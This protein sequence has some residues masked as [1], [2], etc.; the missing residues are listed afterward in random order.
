M[1]SYKYVS[2]IFRANFVTDIDTRLNAYA[3]QHPDYEFVSMC[4]VDVMM[5]MVVFRYK[6]G[7]SEKDE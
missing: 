2:R 3:E 4:A 5:V 6:V 1:E 7:E